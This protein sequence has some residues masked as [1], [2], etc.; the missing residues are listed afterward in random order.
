MSKHLMTQR[1]IP[2]QALVLHQASR[3]KGQP[4]AARPKDSRD[5]LVWVCGALRK[6]GWAQLCTVRV[7]L[8]RACGN[9]PCGD[10]RFKCIDR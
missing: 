8:G 2:N 7:G 5:I 10:G 4:M 9:Q 1:G 3:V 6:M